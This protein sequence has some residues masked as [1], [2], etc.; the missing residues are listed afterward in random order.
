MRN[1]L[2]AGGTGFI[3]SNLV[4]RLIN[5][6]VNVYVLTRP[7]STSEMERLNDVIGIT[8]I[9]STMEELKNIK[10]IPQFDV[11]F[12]LVAYG[13]NYDNQNINDMINTNI[14]F[15]IKIID[16][17]CQNKAKLLI[18]TGS[19]FEYGIN[20]GEKLS[21]ECNLDP[22]SLYASAK[23]S[24]TI[25]GNTYAKLKELNMIT[26]RPFGVYGPG[27]SYY[28]LLPQLIEA[29][30]NGKKLPMTKGEQIRDYLYIDD[31]IDAYIKLGR[32]RNIEPYSIVNICSSESISIKEFVYVFCDVS[33]C[34]KDIFN[35]GEIPYRDNE[36]MYFVGDNSK[37]KSLIDWTPHVSLEDG[38]RMSIEWHRLKS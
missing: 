17:A 36:V 25:I 8:Y 21:E 4:R 14:N 24:G 31:L 23:V 2:V 35:L 28:R 37:I 19:C 26:V 32:C 12:N 22:Q 33:G 10:C 7:N 13:V 30:I 20:K 29:S 9:N 15:V 16:F 3:G 5:D 6:G 38:I 34:D 11:I 1:V 18:H 27:E